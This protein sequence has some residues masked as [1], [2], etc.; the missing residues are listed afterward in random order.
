MSR[1]QNQFSNHQAPNAAF[2]TGSYKSQAKPVKVRPRQKNFDY[3]LRIIDKQKMGPHESS[4]QTLLNAN[5]SMDRL[6]KN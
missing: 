3:L 5:E 2:M 4:T 6:P 1:A